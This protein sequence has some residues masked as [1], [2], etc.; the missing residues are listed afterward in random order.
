LGC[1]VVANECGILQLFT[2]LFKERIV[3]STRVGSSTCTPDELLCGKSASCGNSK[4]TDDA[5]NDDCSKD[6]S[7]D[8]GCF[9]LECESLLAFSCLR[10]SDATVFSRV[11][12][13]AVSTLIKVRV[14]IDSAEASILAGFAAGTTEAGT[15]LFHVKLVAVTLEVGARSIITSARV[16]GADVVVI[17][18]VLYRP[19][20]SAVLACVDVALVGLVGERDR[21]I[22]TF[23]QHNTAAQSVAHGDVHV[24]TSL[25]DGLNI[26]LTLVSALNALVFITDVVRVFA[27]NILLNT[28]VLCH[29]TGHRCAVL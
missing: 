1:L 23:I 26:D 5:G 20:T 28:L 19:Q 17:A 13:D 4:S 6:T 24:S 11:A 3:M 29:I 16:D 12:T 7:T 14:L 22:D 21:I 25:L 9:L 27:D 18:L 8:D 10:V 15:K 2:I